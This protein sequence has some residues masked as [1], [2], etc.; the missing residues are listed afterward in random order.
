VAELREHGGRHYAV[1]SFYAVPDD[2]WYVELSDAVP[3]PEGWAGVPGAARYLPGDVCALAIVP[4][5]DPD[6]E[7]TV[8]LGGPERVV[9]YSIVLWFMEHVS[10]EVERA[11]ARFTEQRP[12]RPA[13]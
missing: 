3:A 12:V 2:A 11:R 6:R 4:D 1:E 9:P 13:P 5:E 10:A 7:P 8:Y